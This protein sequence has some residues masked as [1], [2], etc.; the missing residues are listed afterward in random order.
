[1]KKNSGKIFESIQIDSATNHY[2]IEIPEWVVNDF[3][4][5]EDT[6]VQLSIDSNELIITEREND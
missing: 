1:M 4:W 6:E 5:Y 3:G 2:Y